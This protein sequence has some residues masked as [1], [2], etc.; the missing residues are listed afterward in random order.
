[1]G[2]QIISVYLRD[3]RRIDNVGIVGGTVAGVNGK[4]E[5]PF[6]EEDIVDIKVM[7]APQR[8]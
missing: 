2:F 1:M 5:I 7:N 8:H 4:D 3:G 6:A